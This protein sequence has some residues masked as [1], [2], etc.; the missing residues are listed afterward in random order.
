MRLASLARV[1]YF[2]ITV[3]DQNLIDLY[4]IPVE[5]ID[6]NALRKCAIARGFEVDGE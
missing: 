5:L 4:R 2:R 1:R 6:Q 3:K